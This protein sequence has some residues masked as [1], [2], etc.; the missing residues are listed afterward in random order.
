MDGQMQVRNLP[1]KPIEYYYTQNG[2]SY[3]GNPN[4]SS[5]GINLQGGNQATQSYRSKRGV[6]LEDPNDGFNQV[7]GSQGAFQRELAADAARSGTRSLLNYGFTSFDNGHE[8]AT[9]KLSYE[10]F[11]KNRHMEAI[12]SQWG[13]LEYDGYILATLSPTL[14]VY[15]L[16]TQGGIN[17]DGGR[18]FR[19]AAPTKPEAGLLQFIAET[20]QD[21]P[22]LLGSSV[23]KKGFNRQSAG[24]EFLNLQFGLIPTWSDLQKLSQS[25]LR[26]GNL[27]RQY[28]DNANKQVRRRRALPTVSSV[29]EL[30]GPEAY[31]QIGTF[32]DIPAYSQ[33]WVPNAQLAKTL[34]TD[35]VRSDVWFSGAFT[36]YMN[37]GHSVLDRLDRYEEQANHLLG[38]RFSADT[39]WELSPFSWLADW[40]SDTG[41]FISNVV[42]LDNDELVMKYGYVMHSTSA[43]RTYLKLG[44]TPRPGSSAP[45]SLR[46]DVTFTQKL[47]HKAS[48]YGFGLRDEDL[49]SRQ[50]AILTALGMTQGH[51]S[52]VL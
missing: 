14:P 5:T 7:S 32:F 36:Y 6:S 10:W 9:E 48:P 3:R 29:V 37:E 49:T 47:R 42:A 13:D 51:G 30:A 19:E 11:E 12:G 25:V 45:T 28:R 2:V 4:A 43:T 39:F 38:L 33:F 1:L 46:M 44:L 40:Y 17:L 21:V 27:L 41:T 23:L 8:F 22:R 16:P 50:Q 15:T 20:R 26:A 24:D 18:L 35:V 52:R 31:P 34:V